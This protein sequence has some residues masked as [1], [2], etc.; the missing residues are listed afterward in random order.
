[1][2]KPFLPG[3]RPAFTLIELLVVIAIIA[4]LIGLLLPAIQ[5]VREASNR[6]KCQNNL[7]QIA[8]GSHNYHETAG[9]LPPG[10]NEPLGADGQPDRRCWFQFL[11]PHVEQE[12]IARINNA[13]FPSATAVITSS[14]ARRIPVMLFVCPSDRIGPKLVTG[15]GPTDPNQ[16]GFHGNYVGCGGTT[17]FNATTPNTQAGRQLD[18]LF[19]SFSKVRFAE[20]TDGL[21][22]TLMF[23]EIIVVPDVTFHDTRGRYYNDAAQGGVL[24][25]TR[26][27]PNQ[28]AAPD[29]LG[30]C[31][32]NPR[33]PCTAS[34]V[35]LIQTSRSY[36]PGG[37]NAALGDG[38]VR[39]IAA[40]VDPAT[41]Q[42]LGSRDGGETA[43]DF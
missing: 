43:G 25:S 3:R 38:S 33:A 11:L 5:K 4:V 34:T 23:G 8:L 32:S 19:Y 2:P 36:H 37:V 21:S 18:G 16:Q 24:F 30:Y 10:V 26:Y 14:S 12:A 27:V 35:D 31:Q 9:T 41:W 13:L 42:Y 22:Q 15:T 28:T 40:G 39:F 17:A 1:M 20:V 29:R 6:A 7:K